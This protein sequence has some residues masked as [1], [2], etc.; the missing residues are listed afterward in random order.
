MNKE[1]K[2]KNRGP[3]IFIALFLFILLAF[4]FL[5]QRYTVFPKILI[6][7]IIVLTATFIGK[8]QP[9]IKDWFVFVAFVYLFDS[10]RGSIYL[11]TCKFSL[12]VYAL[13]VIKIENFLFNHIP[14]VVL[15]TRLLNPTSPGKFTWLEKFLTIIHGSHFVAFLLVGFFFW[16][17]KPKVFR[18]YKTSFY[19]AMSAGL[20]GYFLVPTVPPWMASTL[21]HLLP[22]LI[23]FNVVL[24]N[25]LIPDLTSG[26]DT[27]P[28]AAMPSLH[29]LFPILCSLLLWSLYRWKAALFY[30]YTLL[31]LFTII[32][33]GDHYVTDILAGLILAFTC[34]L[35][36][37]KITTI[38][39]RTQ[40]ISSS[41]HLTVVF[42]GLK[43]PVLIGLLLLILGISIGRV[44]KKE[45]M[46]HP[47]NYSL[48]APKYIDFFRHQEKYKTDYKI[49]MYFGTY[50]SIREDYKKA[51]PYF[52]RGSSLA[53]NPSEEKN[54]R[55]QIVF[56]TRMIQAQSR[57]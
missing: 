41:G 29:A 16:Q 33:S 22:P 8:L 19:L 18:L 56:C 31:I 32:Y 36:A 2:F 50:Y 45:F 6:F 9:L 46:G 1:N 4:F 15:Q 24:F 38:N 39:S 44:N 49:Q 3:L 10:L 40:E 27:N 20:L 14:S 11:I 35:V 5:F 51:L 12:P 48:K 23:H 52:Q 57:W 28:I 47:D 7:F 25:I 43:K 54:A 55:Q 26:F 30:L 42:T 53:R 17:Y 13:Y 34:Y 21:F 37:L